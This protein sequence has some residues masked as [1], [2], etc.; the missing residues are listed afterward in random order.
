MVSEKVRCS[1]FAEFMLKSMMEGAV[2]STFGP[3]IEFCL[4]GVPPF[5]F[6][7]AR[8]LVDCSQRLFG[9]IRSSDQPPSF[10]P[11]FLYHADEYVIL[12]TSDINSL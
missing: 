8:Q 1:S 4:P 5:S 10:L 3:K 9:S 6:S 12:S 11:A 2:S 7:E